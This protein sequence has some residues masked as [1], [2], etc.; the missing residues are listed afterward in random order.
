M[1]DIWA[2]GV[3]FYAFIYLDIPFKGDSYEE[4]SNCVIND[5]LTFNEEP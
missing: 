1:I 5:E 4:I 3:T 2:L